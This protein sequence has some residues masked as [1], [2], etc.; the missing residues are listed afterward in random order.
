[1]SVV[2]DILLLTFLVGTALTMARTK[3][4]V[5]AV[6]IFSS[7]GLGMC[8]LWL[9]R[10]APDVAMTEAAVG[11]GIST[12][13]LLGALLVIC[14]RERRLPDL[15]RAFLAAAA[16][17]AVAFFSSFF[18]HWRGVWDSIA[19]FVFFAERAGGAGHEKPW[20][21]Y[22]RLLFW[23]RAGPMGIWSQWPL[24]AF[25]GAA[26]WFAARR[27]GDDVA[28]TS[29]ARF[30]VVFAV[31]L[32]AIYSIIPY[33]TPW[34]MLTPIWALSM[35]AGLGVAALWRRGGWIVRATAALVF[36]AGLAD[37][38]R[39]SGWINGRF[40]ADELNPCVYEH[41][42]PDLLNG[43]RIILEAAAASPDGR[44]TLV[45]VL[46][47]EYW[48]LP[49]YLRSLGRVGYWKELPD[50][51]DAPVVVALPAEL[52]DIE[53]RLRDR[54]VTSIAGLRPGVALYILVREDLWD[55]MMRRRGGGGS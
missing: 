23:H 18:T 32:F 24:L 28:T 49:W 29:F 46:A 39:Q 37:L 21:T 36:A 4:L 48:P 14:L 20:W 11:A 55:E 53:A 54:Y 43:A 44:D 35:A 25:G 5:A 9:H 51:P 47:G 38:R 15:A 31:A 45:R 22:L 17:V 26:A 40:A 2:F 33:K 7:Y 10:G 41:T 52:P 50:A 8:L 27:R 19:A 3:D 1:M 12:V 30:L 13:L 6:V 42:S 34:L 16:G